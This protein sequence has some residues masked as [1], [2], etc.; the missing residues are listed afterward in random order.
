MKNK[1]NMS[2]SL[3]LDNKWSYLK[4]HGDNAW[5]QYPSYFSTV[6]PRILSF[7][8]AHQLRI[9]FF[10]VGQDA[11]FE[12]NHA[13]LQ[14]IVNKGHEIASHSFN[15]DPWLHLYS[16]D[17]LEFD[18]KRAE[19][20]IEEV[21]QV[22]V[23]GFRGPGFSLSTQTL[24]VLRERNYRYDATVFP[25]LLNP[26]ARSYFF[27]KSNLTS[28]EKAQRKALFGTFSD[29]FRSV[30]PYRWQLAEGQLLEIPVTT[31]PFFRVP[32]HFSYLIYLASFSPALAKLYLRIAISACHIS[33]TEPS[34]LLHPL[35]FLGCDDD[36]DL[37]FFPGMKLT[38]EKK[39]DL[40]HEFFS[41]LLDH[42]NAVTMDEHVSGIPNEFELPQCS[43]RF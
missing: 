19:D 32:I 36:A 27:A 2:L 38:A 7:L 42:F 29:A 34:M 11:A 13:D 4:T 37:A 14:S 21:T 10:I 16:K 5:Q 39:L 1:R 43:P 15:H 6:V 20:A 41:I 22:K 40:M 8:D 23:H 3:D 31:M 26:L 28:E 12:K 17:E 35:D 25:N 33:R 24:N 18:L 9:T 30:K